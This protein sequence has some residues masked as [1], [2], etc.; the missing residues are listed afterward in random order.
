MK[1]IGAEV[2]RPDALPV[3]SHMRGMQYHIV[4]N[5][6]I[7]PE[8]KQLYKFVCIIPRQNISINLHCPFIRLLRY[9]WIKVV[10][11]V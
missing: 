11:Q 7:W 5:I 4:L 9:T 6:I 2:L 10:I 3:G 1:S 8:V